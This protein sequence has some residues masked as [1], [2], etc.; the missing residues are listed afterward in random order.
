M[1]DFTNYV[2]PLDN[3]DIFNDADWLE[4]AIT[5]DLL[6]DPA[7]AAAVPGPYLGF[8]S[9]SGPCHKSP[10]GR[11]HRCDSVSDQLD[12]VVG[13]IAGAPDW[14]ALTNDPK[15][16]WFGQYYDEA[17]SADPLQRQTAPTLVNTNVITTVVAN[18]AA[19]IVCHSITEIPR[20]R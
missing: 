14:T 9:C 17:N 1:S 7:I 8:N 6:D 5:L 19:V 10:A 11:E 18:A 3:W 16:P 2:D 20:G 4:A 12:S 13:D 15:L